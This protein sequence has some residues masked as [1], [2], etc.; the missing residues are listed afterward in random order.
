V[1]SYRPTPGNLQ[2]P[3]L[4]SRPNVSDPTAAGN[5]GAAP[6]PNSGTARVAAVWDE[7]AAGR[8]VDHRQGWLDSPVVFAELFQARVS[9]D[10]KIHWLEGLMTRA[11]VPKGGRWASLGCGAAGQEIA[12]GRRGLFS[13]L[14]AYDASTASLDLA[15]REAAEAGLT[16]VRFE[17]IDLDR[18]AL[19]AAA[20]DVVVMNMALHHVREIRPALEAIRT[21]L[22][23]G[24]ALLLNEFVGPRQFQFPDT[25]LEAVRTLLEALPERYRID[26]TSG[27]PK[28]EYVRM[29]VEHWNVADPS[30]AIRSDLILPEVGRLFEIVVRVDYGGT[31][32][33]LLLEHIVHNFDATDE[34]DAA[35]VRLLSAAEA[36]LVDSGVLA[37]DF[38]AI[39]ARPRPAAF[40]VPLPASTAPPRVRPLAL[41][42][43]PDPQVAVL[44]A[45]LAAIHGSRGWRLLQAVRGLFGRRW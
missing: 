9:G 7:I 27:R 30:E 29:P 4:D 14:A 6:A 12:A 17:T 33:N 11:G 31:I 5:A 38:T 13:T 42:R 26:S 41:S 23:P 36:L 20:F 40:D 18:F 43:P 10:P 15:R 8:A 35:L 19:P 39:A 1:L 45:E 32:L 44:A 34:R 21:A 16:G 25:Q 37:S 3:L 2:A 22:A 28:E 24:G